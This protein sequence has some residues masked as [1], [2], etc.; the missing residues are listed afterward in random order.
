MNKGDDEVAARY[1][2]PLL[3]HSRQCIRLLSL[4]PS[5]DHISCTL[6]TFP[7]DAPPPFIALSYEWGP[8][9][10]QAQCKSIKLNGARMAIRTNLY[11]ALGTFTVH[12]FPKEVSAEIRHI[13]IDALCIDQENLQER[14][15]QVNLMAQIYQTAE[16]VVS[17][18]GP[19]DEHPSDAFMQM[20]SKY[21]ERRV[22]AQ[23]D[24]E[25]ISQVA[26]ATPPASTVFARSYWGR[27]WIIQEVLL[28]RKNIVLCGSVSCTLRAFNNLYTHLGD[29]YEQHA[30][31]L[32]RP[33][34]A[35]RFD[36][37]EDFHS[38]MWYM[39]SAAGLRP[40]W[41][42]RGDI[43]RIVDWF[44]WHECTDVRDKINGFGGLFD[45]L[46]QTGG[47]REEDGTILI[48]SSNS[49]S[50]ESNW[51]ADYD[52][53]VLETLVRFLEFATAQPTEEDRFHFV[54]TMAVAMGLQPC[55]VFARPETQA[56]ISVTADQRPEH[57]GARGE[58]E[59]LRHD[60]ITPEHWM[61]ISRRPRDEVPEWVLEG[62]RWK[63][64]GIG[65]WLRSRY[66]IRFVR[67][68]LGLYD[69]FEGVILKDGRIVGHAK[70]KRRVRKRT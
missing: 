28:A 6:D 7:L 57:K 60:A 16:A 25:A 17:W 30:K 69:Q 14:N 20:A 22:Y 1:Y 67:W 58:W 15:H 55:A 64:C 61:R 27:V 2:Y 68:Y 48:A 32:R 31:R 59:Y 42:E 3:D 39:F 45:V 24:V 5:C 66:P 13:W 11:H 10:S 54:I 50:S 51:S 21:G 43:V 49:S 62:V 33:P 52:R 40:M 34:P 70:P 35:G 46:Q 18:L 56:F 63:V 36:G 65:F 23:E 38:L 12:G 29:V 37:T 41:K 47:R 53:D 8:A 4:S 26:L 44:W 9:I 19:A